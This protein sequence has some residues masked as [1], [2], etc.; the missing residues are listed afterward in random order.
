MKGK[1]V[2]NI[3]LD[4]GCSKTLVYKDLVPADKD[5]EG[6]VV[7]I[8]CAH[9]DT[10]LYPIANVTLVVDG[11]QVQVEAAVSETLPVSV[12]L[13]TDVAILEELLHKQPLHYMT[14]DVLVVLTHSQARRHKELESQGE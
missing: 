8:K 3:V 4:T 14:K 9:G 6:D 7:T 11:L 1:L 13:S 10:V 2:A 5:M 12:L